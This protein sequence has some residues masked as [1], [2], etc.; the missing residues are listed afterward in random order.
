MIDLIKAE[1]LTISYYKEKHKNCVINNLSFSIPKNSV[2]GVIGAS[3][4]GKT[5]LLRALICDVVSNLDIQGALFYNNLQYY[6]PDCV[7][8][9]VLSEF[10]FIPQF[11]ASAISPM[12]TIGQV[13]FD[14]YL[15]RY[16]NTQKPKIKAIL[17]CELQKLDLPTNISECYPHELSGGMLQRALLAMGFAIA[18]SVL[19]LDEPTSAL[20]WESQLSVAKRIIEAQTKQNLTVVVV[21][22][23]KQFLDSI[24]THTLSLDIGGDERQVSICTQARPKLSQITT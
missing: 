15:S 12:H 8:T 9:S 20:D 21:S 19:V 5:S 6:S 24:C 11:T 10:F 23:D 22:H 14:L 2:F 13:F 17:G 7:M 18:P 1:N 4:V 16:P 3:G